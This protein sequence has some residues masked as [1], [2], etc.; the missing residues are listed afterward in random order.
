M[1]ELKSR[2]SPYALS[3]GKLSTDRTTQSIQACSLPT[4]SWVL[5]LVDRKH[6]LIIHGVTPMMSCEQGVG[7]SGAGASM[8]KCGSAGGRG[9][10]CSRTVRHGGPIGYPRRPGNSSAG[11]VDLAGGRCCDRRS[12]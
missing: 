2:C 6:L 3:A 9:I 7:C 12:H 8:A 10:G 11:L 5:G 4:V 1:F